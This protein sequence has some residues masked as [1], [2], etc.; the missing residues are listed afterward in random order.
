MGQREWR[1]IA[2]HEPQGHGQLRTPHGTDAIF[3]IRK[4]IRKKKSDRKK[5]CMLNVK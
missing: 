5:D 2:W 4:I 1:K 3:L